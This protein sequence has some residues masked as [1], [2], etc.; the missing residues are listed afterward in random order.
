MPC[1]STP[2]LD[3]ARDTKGSRSSKATPR[4]RV[5]AFGFGLLLA[6]LICNSVSA[7]S[8]VGT[9][10]FNIEGNPPS[11]V[12]SAATFTN[13]KTNTSATQDWTAYTN[14]LAMDSLAIHVFNST[15]NPLSFSNAAF[16][17]FLGNVVSDTVTTSGSST[18]AMTM[19][20]IIASGTFTPG[21]TLISGGYTSSVAAQFSFVSIGYASGTRSDMAVMSTVPEPATLAIFAMGSATLFG[22]ARRKRAMATT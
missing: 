8:I 7:A 12:S 15:G 10:G 17:T 9:I 6:A 11:N 20:Q 4:N 16:G 22:L 14:V 19:R 21:T 13:V 1:L 18:F 2:N 5:F 3:S